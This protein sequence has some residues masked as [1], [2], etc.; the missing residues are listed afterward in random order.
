[1]KSEQY[2]IPGNY[3]CGSNDTAET[4]KNCPFHNS[5]L[6][7]V[8]RALGGN[9]NYIRQTFIKYDDSQMVSRVYFASSKSWQTEKWNLPIKSLWSGTMETGDSVTI[10]EISKYTT[11]AILN[12]SYPIMLWGMRWNNRILAFGADCNPNNSIRVCSL[13]LKISNNNVS[14]FK[15]KVQMMDSN[16]PSNA[17][18][19]NQIYGIN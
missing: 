13:V 18:I 4:L 11:F 16:E 3:Y 5:F 1:M 6:L 15:S 17:F 7:K 9:D 19:I 12:S 2:T 8:E 14:I 10:D